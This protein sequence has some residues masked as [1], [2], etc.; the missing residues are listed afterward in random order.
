MT[1]IRDYLKKWATN[2]Q[3]EEHTFKTV[4]NTAV[5]RYFGADADVHYLHCIADVVRAVRKQGFTVRSRKSSV[6][7]GSVGQ[8]RKQ[9][10]KLGL[11]FYI[12]RVFGHV[13]LLDHT[14]KTVVDTDP[15]KRDRRQIT[16][17]YKVFTAYT[18]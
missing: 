18:N 3:G 2:L 15:R 10:K 9:L 17:L 16:H 7:I 1:V 4:C 14:G 6:K 8:V 5:T 12:V 11:G 13:L